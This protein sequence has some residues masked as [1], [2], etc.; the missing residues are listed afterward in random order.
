VRYSVLVVTDDDEPSRVIKSKLYQQGA[1][2]I[3]IMA[4]ENK[5]RLPI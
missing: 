5:S 3:G 1:V 2:V 4:R